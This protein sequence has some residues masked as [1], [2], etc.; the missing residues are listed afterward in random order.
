MFH[1][2]NLVGVERC[3]QCGIA[4]PLLSFS[5]LMTERDLG[6][7][8]LQGWASY[9]CSSCMGL[10]GASG[11]F[12]RGAAASFAVVMVQHPTLAERIIPEILSIDDAIP[13]SAKRYLEQAIQSKHIPDGS[14]MLSASAVDAMLKAKGYDD[15]SLFSRV[16][17]AVAD[18]I[19]TEEMGEWAHMVR[20]ESN[21]P[22]HVDEN[23]PHAT[24]DLAEQTVQFALALADFLFVLPARIER[25]KSHP[26]VASNI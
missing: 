12:P 5:S 11:R 17:E 25:G 2:K 19:L 18:R 16:K 9:Q 3:P 23:E 26:A 20:L 14:V 15:G 22:R 6:G 13:Q 24:A 10:I 8:P 1:G 21:K 4:N 7:G